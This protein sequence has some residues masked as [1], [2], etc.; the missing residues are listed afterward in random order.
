MVQATN[1]MT[2]LTYFMLYYLSYRQLG[3]LGVLRGVVPWLLEGSE[4]P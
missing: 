4:D 1:T 2:L 3:D